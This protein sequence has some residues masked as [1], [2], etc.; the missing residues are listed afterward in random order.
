[1]AHVL[2]LQHRVN[3]SQEFFQFALLARANT[4]DRDAK[5]RGELFQINPN[6]ARLGLIHHIYTENHRRT[7]LHDLQR[8]IEITRKASRVTDHYHRIRPLKAQKIPRGCFLR[9]ACQ[10]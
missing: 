9:G 8:E 7:E 3:R 4:D 6:A 5:A 10:Q 2:I 1:M